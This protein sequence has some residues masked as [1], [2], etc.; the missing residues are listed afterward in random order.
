MTADLA[1]LP[2]PHLFKILWKGFTYQ[3]ENKRMKIKKFQL[4]FVSF[5]WRYC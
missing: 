1:R 4:L 3:M 2:D 5:C